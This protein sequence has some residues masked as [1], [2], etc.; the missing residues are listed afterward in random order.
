MLAREPRMRITSEEAILN[1]WVQQKG[2]K[3]TNLKDAK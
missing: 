1:K 3:A 2:V